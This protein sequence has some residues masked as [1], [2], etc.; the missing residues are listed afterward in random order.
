MNAPRAVAEFRI[1]MSIPSRVIARSVL[2]FLHFVGRFVCRVPIRRSGFERVREM[3]QSIMVSNH[4]SLLD[5]P[6]LF[7]SIPASRRN[8]TATVGGLDFFEA[9]SGQPWFERLFRRSVIWFIRSAMNVMLIDRVGG[10]YSELDRIDAMIAAGWS[11]VIFP[12][13]TR[14]RDGRLGRFRHGAA[15]LARRNDLPVIPVRIEG[16]EYIL[17][18]GVGWPRSAALRMIAGEPMRAAPDETAAAFTKRLAAAIE[19][20]STSPVSCEVDRIE[21][22]TPEHAG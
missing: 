15:E 1:P 13:A 22:L 7:M 8:R 2:S 6:L 5:T 3:P 12:E 17:P 14:S 21:E 16:T 10:E 19:A 20:L 18:P 9:E 4:H 11:L